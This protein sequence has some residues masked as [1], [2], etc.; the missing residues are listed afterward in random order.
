[1]ANVKAPVTAPVEGC[2]EQ[3]AL[4][5]RQENVPYRNVSRELTSAALASEAPAPAGIVRV[6]ERP[7]DAASSAC[8]DTTVLLPR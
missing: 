4:R 3:S 7:S 5:S 1:L 8:P 2:C 6:T